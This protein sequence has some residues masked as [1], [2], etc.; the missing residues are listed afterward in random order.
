M[1]QQIIGP[2]AHQPD[3]PVTNHLPV[4]IGLDRGSPGN[5]KLEILKLT[6]YINHHREQLVNLLL[7]ATRKKGHNRPII[8]AAPA[9]YTA[10]ECLAKLQVNVW[11]ADDTAIV[12]YIITAADGHTVSEYPVITAGHVRAAR[13]ARALIA[14][15]EEP[16]P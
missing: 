5:D 16:T 10:L 15:L 1:F 13:K 11:D 6:G 4:I 7:P 14:K 12:T 3:I 9:M 2:V 8:K